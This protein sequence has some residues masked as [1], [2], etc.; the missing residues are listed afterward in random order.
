MYAVSPLLQLRGLKAVSGVAMLVEQLSM[1]FEL[2]TG[3][4]PDSTRMA[5][6]VQDCLDGAGSRV[7]DMELPLPCEGNAGEE[8][9]K[10]QRECWLSGAAER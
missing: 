4:K 3:T 7:Q 10:Q 8:N 1:Q 5:K 6:A 2:L 9:Y